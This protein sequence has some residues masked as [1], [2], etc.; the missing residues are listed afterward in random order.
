MTEQLELMNKYNLKEIR[1]RMDDYMKCMEIT[2]YSKNN[3]CVRRCIPIVE[4]PKVGSLWFSVLYSNMG[5]E[6]QDGETTDS[7]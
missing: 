3:K 5:K 7:N 4:I 2:F 1:I 6:L